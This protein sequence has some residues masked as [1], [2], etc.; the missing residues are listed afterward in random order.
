MAIMAVIKKLNQM[1]HAE[2][3]FLASNYTLNY[4]RLNMMKQTCICLP[5]KACVET[6]L[7]SAEEALEAAGKQVKVLVS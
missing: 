6:T 2:G 1:S 5:L 3:T 7:E 4:S